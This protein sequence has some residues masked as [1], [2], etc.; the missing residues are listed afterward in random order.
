[1]SFPVAMEWEVSDSEEN[2]S[3]LM[4]NSA[5]EAETVPAPIPPP[6]GA[7]AR[8]AES[9]TAAGMGTG[10]GNIVRRW[11]REDLLKKSSL[12]AR[13]AALLFSLLAFI[14]MASNKHGDWKDFD[15]Y[16]E[17]RHSQILILYKCLVFH[18]TTFRQ[19][20]ELSTGR[21]YS[22]GRNWGMIDFFGDQVAAYLLISSASSAV[23][24][25]NRMRESN[26]NLFTDS[27]ASAISM[28]FLAF[29]AM[30]ISAV[31]SGYKLSRQS[32]I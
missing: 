7:G 17:Y 14:I 15:R 10:V 25:T 28:E 18:S 20:H 3:D 9:Q 29:L 6:P 21:I 2:M 1:M 12:G 8:D 26:D 22:S 5:K 32:Y 31:I 19:L 30:A 4:N 16:E 27:S 13:A 23:P 11:R 24:M